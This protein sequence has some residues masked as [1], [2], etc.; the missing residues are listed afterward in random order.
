MFLRK[1]FSGRSFTAIT[2][3]LGLELTVQEEVLFDSTL[4][5]SELA[6]RYDVSA[7]WNWSNPLM[8][9]YTHESMSH[10]TLNSHWEKIECRR[11]SSFHGVEICSECCMNPTQYINICLPFYFSDS[12]GFPAKRV[13]WGLISNILNAMTILWDTFARH[14]CHLELISMWFYYKF[15]QN[16]YCLNFIVFEKWIPPFLW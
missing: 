11:H 7:I 6:T 5:G 15:I 1:H 2:S 12:C 3:L 10:T 9:S 13:G 16:S 4:I 14:R 8:F